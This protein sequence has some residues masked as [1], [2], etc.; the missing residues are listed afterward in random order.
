MASDLTIHGTHKLPFNE[1]F[2][3]SAT[4]NLARDILRFTQLNN[5]IEDYFLCK[6]PP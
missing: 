2:H 3:K 5:V 6:N 1:M 4:T